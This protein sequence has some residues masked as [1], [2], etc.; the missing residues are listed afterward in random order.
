MLDGMSRK[1]LHRIVSTSVVLALGVGALGCTTLTRHAAG[2]AVQDGQEEPVQQAQQ[3]WIALFDGKSLD[4]W[5]PKIRGLPAGENYADTFRVEDGLLKVRYDGYDAWG[6]R[7]G[8][9]FYDKPFSHYR[10]RIEYRFSGEQIDGGPGWAK[11]N[12]GIMIHG[13]SPETMTENQEFPVSL[14]VQLL[15]AEEGK[16]PTANVCTPGTHIE[17]DGQLHTQHCTNSTSPT[18]AP[19]EW[20]TVEL[21]VRGGEVIRHLVNGEE[22]L[23]Y[24]HPVLDENDADA[25]RLLD[26]GA[27]VQLTSGTISLQSESHPVEF[28]KVELLPLDAPAE[29][30]VP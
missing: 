23:R 15:A 18:F 9:L 28:R 22:V 4:G 17:L 26:A 12:S 20:V 14:E 24:A 5:T 10:L 1:T 13:Q 21:E 2:R 30:M 25:K 11:L 27:P 7:F 8:H 6:N 3:A 19:S 29:P 16:R